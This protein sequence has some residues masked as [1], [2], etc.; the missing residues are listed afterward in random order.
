MSMLKTWPSVLYEHCKKAYHPSYLWLDQEVLHCR[1][2]PDGAWLPSLEA[3][4][5]LLNK[6]SVLL[7]IA[8]L[9]ESITYC[10][11]TGCGSSLSCW[12]NG[13]PYSQVRPWRKCDE[14]LS[15]S[16]Q[17]SGFIK[18]LRRWLRTIGRW[19][20]HE[21]KDAGH[22]VSVSFTMVLILKKTDSKYAPLSRMF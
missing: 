18:L 21:P 5:I 14:P 2:L 12:V 11:C 15:K 22:G 20:T 17:S 9:M 19:R 13:N 1:S 8:L 6:S 4:F 16:L 3:R 7:I 10:G